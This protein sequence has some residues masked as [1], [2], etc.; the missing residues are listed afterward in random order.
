MKKNKINCNIQKIFH[1]F[2]DKLNTNYQQVAATVYHYKQSLN[3]SEEETTKNTL[4]LEHI[5][6]HDFENFCQVLEC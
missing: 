1:K 5:A 4:T 2:Y 3:T 6:T